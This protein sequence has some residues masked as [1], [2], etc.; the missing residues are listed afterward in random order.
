MPN[1]MWVGFL[2]CEHLA[3]VLQDNGYPDV[4]YTCRDVSSNML[5]GSLPTA[6]GQDG[7]GNTAGLQAEFM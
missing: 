2:Q 4:F 7:G 3:Q 1:H 5:S 6:W